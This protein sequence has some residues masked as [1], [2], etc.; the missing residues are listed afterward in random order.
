MR[1]GTVKTFITVAKYDAVVWSP[2]IPLAINGVSPVA[3]DYYHATDANVCSMNNNGIR[4]G[5][6]SLMYDSYPDGPTQN[7]T[8]P[9]D[10]AAGHTVSMSAPAD[11]LTDVAIWYSHN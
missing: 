10:Y 9:T 8:M 4:P 3:A 2:A 1:D 6:M 7:I 11:L 5:M